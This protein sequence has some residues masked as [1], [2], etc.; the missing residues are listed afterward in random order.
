[1]GHAY[2]P[3]LK[4]TPKI[5]LKK[6]R[7]LPLKGDVVVEKGQKVSAD[8]VVARTELP[9]K[10]IPINAANI[11][12]VQ[13]ADLPEHITVDLDTKLK[14]GEIYA[15]AKVLFGLF[16]NHLRAPVDDVTLENVSQITGKVLLREKPMPVE[17]KAY[18]EGTITEIYPGEGVEVES[19][20]AMAQGIFGIGGETNGAL[21]MVCNSPDEPLTPDKI[22]D[23]HAG[24]IIVGGSIVTAAALQTAIQKKVRAIVVGGFNDQDLRNFLGYDLGVAITGSENKGIS[25]VVTEGFGEIPMTERTFNLLKQFEGQ[26]ACCHGATQIRAGVIRPEVVIPM[27]ESALHKDKEVTAGALQIGTPIRVIREPYFGRIGK[28]SDLPPAPTPLESETK[29]RVLKLIFDDDGK[30]AMVPRANVEILET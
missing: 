20:A 25:L 1:M 3:G 14:K 26:K 21:K 18:I 9:G 5:L 8:D 16:K 23:D 12:G 6:K 27:S 29:A 2:T 4:V 24:C 19:W 15:T 28:V 11:L 30:E 17:V 13:P 7:I 22:Q 10:V